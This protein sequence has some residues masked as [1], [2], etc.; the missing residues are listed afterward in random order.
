MPGGGS[1]EVFALDRGGRP[2]GA[3]AAAAP[4][5]APSDRA[6]RAARVPHP[7]RDQGRAGRDRRPVPSRS[8]RAPTPGVRRAVLRDGARSTVRRSRGGI[9]DGVG[10][11]PRDAAPRASRSSSTRSSRCTP[12]T[13]RASGSPTWATPEGFLERQVQRWLAQLDVLRRARSSGRARDRTLARRAPPGRPAADAVPR[14]L[15][16]RQ[17]AV[18]ARQRRPGCSPS[19][20]GRW[21]RSAT[22]SSTSRGR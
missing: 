2:L 19:S 16:A 15:Q 4:R 3:A 8:S 18:R 21:R 7:R 10:G 13:G 5:E 11:R 22:R 1:C 14:R 6:R 9:P 17:R 20:T 12:S